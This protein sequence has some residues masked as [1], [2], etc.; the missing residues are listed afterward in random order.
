MER[1]VQWKLSSLSLVTILVWAQAVAHKVEHAVVGRLSRKCVHS[2]NLTT[3]CEP[4]ALAATT[5]EV[6]ERPVGERVGS[7]CSLPQLA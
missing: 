2:W 6:P 7:R 5:C 1:G 4:W 3:N